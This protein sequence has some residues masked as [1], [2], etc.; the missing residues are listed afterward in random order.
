M[1]KDSSFANAIS[2]VRNYLDAVEGGDLKAANL[3]LR[4]GFKL[5]FP[6]GKSFFCLEEVIDWAELRYRWV[7]KSYDHF[8]PLISEEGFIVYCFGTLYGEWLDGD[9][10]SNIRLIDRFTIK[11]GKIT[12]QMVWNDLGEFKRE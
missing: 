10:F 9:E 12:E 7:K 5:V 3:W 11:D 6:G 8:D 2:L 4:E 1:E